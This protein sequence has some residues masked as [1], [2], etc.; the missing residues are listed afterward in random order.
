MVFNLGG[1]SSGGG[2]Q[3]IRQELPGQQRPFVQDL[4]T[5][6]QRAFQATPNSPF[7]QRFTPKANPYEERALRMARNTAIGNRGLGR[8]SNAIANQFAGDV[9]GG[10]YAAGNIPTFGSYA[11][12]PQVQEVIRAST[13]P[14]FE[15]FSER[16]IPQLQSTATNLG[17]SGGS[18]ERQILP[19]IAMRDFGREVAR[20]GTQAAFEDFQ[21]QRELI[22]RMGLLEQQAASLVPTLAQQGYNLNLLPSQTISQV[23]AGQRALE[24]VERQEALR[25]YQNYIDAPWQGLDRYAGIVYGSPSAMNQDISVDGGGGIGGLASGAIGG[26]ISGALL[27]NTLAGATGSALFPW[28]GAGLAAGSLLGLIG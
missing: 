24:N 15:E 14:V 10:R 27:G 2:N 3:T 18:A 26:G 25:Q 6:A 22:P 11:A 9:E 1:G 12:T 5:Q 28:A 17:A 16:L 8:T 21:G 7:G 19:E 23:G 13:Q 20:I 4:Y